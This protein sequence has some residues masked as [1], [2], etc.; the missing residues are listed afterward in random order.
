MKI[1]EMNEKE[2]PRERLVSYG[3]ASL[4]SAELLAI[5]LRTG[6]GSRNV[7]ELSQ[8]LL[9]CAG[10]LTGLSSMSIERLMSLPGIGRD[11]AASLMAAFEIGRRF[12]A[13]K[14]EGGIREPITNSGQVYSIMIPVMKGLDHEEC[15]V[16][17]LNRSNYVLVKEKISVGGLASTTF[18]KMSILRKAIERKASG[19]IVV[20]NHPSGNPYPGTEDIRETASLKKASMSFGI[21]LMDHVI[22]SDSCWYSFADESVTSAEYDIEDHHQHETRGKP[23]CPDIG[24]AAG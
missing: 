3:A 5:L 10:S 8:E 16:I 9:A 14:A 7:L 6:S 21:S 2:R 17:F 1:K 12:A 18:D 22:V 15:W 20:H 19:L 24:M 23:D 4:G 11:K 13:E